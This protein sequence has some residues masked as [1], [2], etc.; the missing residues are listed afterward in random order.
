MEFRERIA[1]NID[2]LIK[3]SGKTKTQVAEELGVNLV[4]VIDYT[5]GRSVPGLESFYLLCKIL[6]CEYTEI[7][8]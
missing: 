2:D 8:D 7:L 6:G 4:T 3:R 5:K 1:W